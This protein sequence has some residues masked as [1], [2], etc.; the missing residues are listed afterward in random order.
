MRQVLALALS[1]LVLF[2]GC[3]GGPVEQK[4]T[5]L[6][7]AL[8][9][10]PEDA[11]VVA[12]FDAKK[13]LAS[14]AAVEKIGL[15]KDGVKLA[16]LFVNDAFV[17][18]LPDNRFAYSFGVEG[19]DITLFG[20]SFLPQ[21]IRMIDN[22]TDTN[23]TASDYQGRKLYSNGK[24]AYFVAGGRVYIGEESAVKKVAGVKAGK[25]NAESKFA[26]VAKRVPADSDFSAVME[27]EGDGL[28][29]MFEGLG[30]A[31]YVDGNVS[32]TFVIIKAKDVQAAELIALGLEEAL[33]SGQQEGASVKS[34]ETDSEMVFVRFAVEISKFDP[35]S[36]GIGGKMQTDDSDAPSVEG[37]IVVGED[38]TNASEWEFPEGNE[39][40]YDVP[41]EY[42]EDELPPVPE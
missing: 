11:E 17:A 41:P 8:S 30:V 38:G 34:V 18:L 2:S 35:S 4:K 26:A 10:S 24:L 29:G 14:E 16:R 5:G 32:D 20:S 40:E 3:I 19:G 15:G 23:F 13:L 6:A 28:S 39:S 25:T 12:Y 7:L 1:L 36:I 42:W 21:V 22:R 37:V 33:T 27:G 31:G 9:E